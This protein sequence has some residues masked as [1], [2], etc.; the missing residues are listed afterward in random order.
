MHLDFGEERREDDDLLFFFK[1]RILLN[2]FKN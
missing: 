1:L 2:V